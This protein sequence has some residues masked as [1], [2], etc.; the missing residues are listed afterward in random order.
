LE[1][2]TSTPFFKKLCEIDEEEGSENINSDKNYALHEIQNIGVKRKR[3]LEDLFGD[4]YDIELEDALLKRHKTEEQRDFETIQKILDARKLFDS[5][6]NPLKKTNY[7]RYEAMHKFKKE[8]LS[9][10]IPKYF[11]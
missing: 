4:I 1:K 8:N 10:T 5:Q 2:K 7:D 9:R 6:V 11:N 3:R